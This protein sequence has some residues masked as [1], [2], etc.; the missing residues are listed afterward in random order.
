MAKPEFYG[1]SDGTTKVSITK[2]YLRIRKG[3]HAQ[4]R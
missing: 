3:K 4:N 2:E 1:R